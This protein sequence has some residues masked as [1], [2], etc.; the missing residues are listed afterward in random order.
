MRTTHRRLRLEGCHARRDWTA[1]EWNHVIFSNVSRFNF[2]SD[3]NR[4]HVWRHRGERLNPDVALKR[5]T[6]LAAGMMVRGVIVC[7]S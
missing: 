2:I 6:A 4:V 5:H 7:D 3:D 1:T